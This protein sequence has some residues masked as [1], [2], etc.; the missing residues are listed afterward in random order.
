MRHANTEEIQ[1]IDKEVADLTAK[2][3]L[4]VKL[5]QQQAMGAEDYHQRVNE[6]NRRILALRRKRSGLLYCAEESQHL[7]ELRDLSVL[8]KDSDDSW[9]FN[10]EI[11]LELVEKMRVISKEKITFEI[12]GEIPLTEHVAG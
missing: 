7:G 5:Y 10:S 8:L 3:H 11:F 12:L 6:I 9:T 4:L 1:R 2:N